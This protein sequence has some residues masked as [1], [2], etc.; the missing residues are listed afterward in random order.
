M[1][2]N[3]FTRLLETDNKYQ[4]GLNGRFWVWC[5]HGVGMAQAQWRRG[6]HKGHTSLKFE[7]DG[8]LTKRT[9]SA[10]KLI[11]DQNLRNWDKVGREKP[12]NAPHL[13]PEVSTWE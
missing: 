13:A 12:K 3:K 9:N 7:K 2:G 4:S 10:P 5:G 1:V 6:G 11:T 8:C